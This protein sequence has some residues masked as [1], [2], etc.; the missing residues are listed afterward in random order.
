MLESPSSN[1]SGLSLVDYPVQIAN[2]RRS[3]TLTLRR[4]CHPSIANSMH[5]NKP[6]TVLVNPAI[7]PLLQPA[8]FS[9]KLRS[10]SE[11]II[12][13]YLNTLITLFTSNSSSFTELLNSQELALSMIEVLSSNKSENVLILVLSFLGLVFPKCG[14]TKQHLIDQDLVCY[15]TNFLITGSPNLIISTINILPI[16]IDNS[17]YAR[18]SI[19]YYDVFNILADFAKNRG[20]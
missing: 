19:L 12:R 3:R 2:E 20:I 9:K 5:S 18:D 6:H 10:N 4:S 8:T 13:E 15:L 1:A 14:P 7:Y 11:S 17:S 16:L